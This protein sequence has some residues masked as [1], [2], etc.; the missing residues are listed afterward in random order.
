MAI[1]INFRCRD[2]ESGGNLGV[3]SWIAPNGQ[4]LAQCQAA[5]DLLVPLIEACIGGY[6]E[7]IDGTVAFTNT[8]TAGGPVGDGVFNERG[9]VFLMDT[10]GPKRESV[11]LP[12]ILQSKM[13]GD[14]V[15]LSDTEIAALLDAYITGLNT[16]S[17]VVKPDT[18]FGY[19]F[20]TAVRGIKSGRK[21]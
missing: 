18:P 4:T 10:T 14:T 11:R 19:K 6:V 16:G 13:G 17:G 8:Q 7:T 2:S 12:Q 1:T 20:S 9:A 15:S 5:A 3:I 21:W